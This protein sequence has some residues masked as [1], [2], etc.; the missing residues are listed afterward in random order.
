MFSDV[1][2]GMLLLLAVVLGGLWVSYRRATSQ[3]E[4]NRAR[5][6][7]G[8]QATRVETD[9]PA[10]GQTTLN[11]GPARTD[12]HPEPV[13]LPKPVQL[14]G[15]VLGVLGLAMFVLIVPWSV[16]LFVPGWALLVVPVVR[17][18]RTKS[19]FRLW[20]SYVLAT[21]ASALL[22]AL[23]SALVMADPLPSATVTTQ[24]GQV[25]GPLIAI[26]DGVVYLG[27]VRRDDLFQSVPTSKVARLTVE[28]RRRIQDESVL[29]MLGWDFPYRRC[30]NV[31]RPC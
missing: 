31:V 30:R 17:R 29:Q 3:S 4:R 8:A 18:N 25:A 16:L 19:A 20:Q 6:Q 13:Q 11:V 23:V 2:L 5:E 24:T 27:P 9:K 14:A 1:V 26:N 21:A 7:P 10:H 15:P 28:R 12:A 22:T